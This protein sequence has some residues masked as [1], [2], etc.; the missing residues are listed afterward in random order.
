M[1]KLLLLSAF[2]IFACSS[3]EEK[4]IITVNEENYNSENVTKEDPRVADVWDDGTM[5]IMNNTSKNL[6]I[7]SVKY[8]PK[9]SLE[10]LSASVTNMIND[11]NNIVNP[12]YSYMVSDMQKEAKRSYFLNDEIDILP[13]LNAINVNVDYLFSAPPEVKMVDKEEVNWYLH[14]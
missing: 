9:L 8:N 4:Q 3:D 12:T 14:R 5:F 2:L 7:E 1:K 13:G 6:T 10:N 11:A